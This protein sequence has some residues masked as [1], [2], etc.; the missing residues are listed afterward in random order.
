MG[1]VRAD[2]DERTIAIHGY[3]KNA[4][5]VGIVPGVAASARS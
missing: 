5:R 3:A 4:S 1:G 2:M